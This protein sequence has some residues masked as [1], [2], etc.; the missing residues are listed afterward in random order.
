MYDCMYVLVYECI[1]YECLSVWDADRNFKGDPI[2]TICLPGHQDKTN[3][4]IIDQKINQDYQKH[5][6]SLVYDNEIPSGP[7]IFPLS[8]YSA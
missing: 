1:V 4:N 8:I 7:L 6:L 5:P 2:L 3:Q